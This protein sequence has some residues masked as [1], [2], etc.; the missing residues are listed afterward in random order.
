MLKTKKV[1]FAIELATEYANK[2]MLNGL[3]LES[4]PDMI[5]KV[6]EDKT[7]E[8][9]LYS[10]SI[11]T[12]L[13]YNNPNDTLY[14]LTNILFNEDF[15]VSDEAVLKFILMNNNFKP[16]YE[17]TFENN[18]IKLTSN[19][20]ENI[21]YRVETSNVP[22]DFVMVKPLVSTEKDQILYNEFMHDPLVF[23]QLLELSK[24][25]KFP[26]NEEVMNNS[27]M[28]PI[29]RRDPN[30]GVIYLFKGVVQYMNQY[31]LAKN[32]MSFDVNSV[33][34]QTGKLMYLRPE[35][36]Y[37]VW[38][39]VTSCEKNNKPLKESKLTKLAKDCLKKQPLLISEEQF[40]EF[41]PV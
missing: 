29:H 13:I 31:K 6:E 18:S 16:E 33:E 19:P 40:L 10:T 5:S 3:E 39:L 38:N 30:T 24:K 23:K 41:D 35:F 15:N 32:F 2:K 37:D 36:A 28:L 21:I 11:K 22:K 4:I 9:N 12:R 25:E 8:K 14:L 27:F 20:E 1:I 7:L 34:N 17:L 26:I